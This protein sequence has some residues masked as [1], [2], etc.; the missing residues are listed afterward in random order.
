M[1]FGQTDECL[2][3]GVPLWL[4]SPSGRPMFPFSPT[5]AGRAIYPDV[6]SLVL[7]ETVAK[8]KLASM[9]DDHQG[10]VRI[11]AYAVHLESLLGVLLHDFRDDYPLIAV[12]RASISPPEASNQLDELLWQPLRSGQLDLVFGGDHHDEFNRHVLY[13]TATVADVPPDHKW[14][15]AGYVD[16]DDLAKEPLGVLP[17]GYFSRDKME[18]I[19]GQ[20]ESRGPQ[21]ERPTVRGLRILR[22]RG[23][24]PIAA[25][26]AVGEIVESPPLPRV[27]FEGKLL[28]DMT[29]H[30][31]K[32]PGFRPI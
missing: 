1:A 32:S 20:W 2:S 29:M 5:P 15:Q 26:D 24:V 13:S 27:H 10:T 28:W 12:E 6:K 31:R 9:N 21:V 17:L 8:K 7:S 3:A 23:V 4:S 16:V 11:G 30:W 25:D 14:R 18:T 19:F 22:S